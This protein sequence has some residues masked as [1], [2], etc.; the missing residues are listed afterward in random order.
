MNGRFY[1]TVSASGTSNYVSSRLVKIERDRIVF[2]S[3]TGSAR[4]PFGHVRSLSLGNT[5][6]FSLKLIPAKQGNFSVIFVSGGARYSL[7][8]GNPYFPVY[9]GE[10]FGPNVLVEIW[11]EHDVNV[12]SP[13]FYIPIS[14]LNYPDVCIDPNFALYKLS[15]VT[16]KVV[17]YGT[18]NPLC[19]PLEIT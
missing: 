10:L 7:W 18:C 8:K 19:L 5:F 4:Y 3:F 6:K 11:A 16:A 1:K 15:P 9:S 17:Y 14:R 2:Y 12:S 13:S